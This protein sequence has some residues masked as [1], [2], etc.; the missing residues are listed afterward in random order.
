MRRYSESLDTRLV[1]GPFALFLVAM[2]L[3]PAVHGRAAQETAPLV[4]ANA[5][6]IDG[7][8]AGPRPDVTLVIEN[9]RIASIVEGDAPETPPGA[10]VVDLSGRFILPGLIDAHVHL[11]SNPEAE[12]ALRELLRAGVTTVRDMGG[13]ARTL[14]VLARDVGLGEIPA[15]DIHY[16]A[17]FY[18]PAFLQDPRS[19]L[20]ARGREPG[21]APWSRVVTEDSDLPQIVAEARGAGATGIKIY[22]AM[23]PELLARV[24]KE[25][26]AQGLKVWSHATI[27][28]S[29]P[30][31]AV[32]AGVHVLSHSGGL[33]PEARPDVPDSYTEA[34]ME[35]M[36]KQDFAAV[37]PAA[38]PFDDLY[39]SM[40]R[41]GT[42]LE[43]TMSAGQRQRATRGREEQAEYLARAARRIDMAARWQWACGATR[44]ASEAGVTIVAGTDSNGGVPVA[45][46]MET[47][48]RCG[49]SPLDAIRAATL[50]A[51]RAIGIEATHG[52]VEVGKAADLAIVAGDPTEDIANVRRVVGTVKAGRLYGAESADE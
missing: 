25:A 28:P 16:S 22:S 51:A 11:S 47:L 4:L 44:A 18:G 2:L 1:R 13:D 37:D 15:P 21:T 14:A 32:A 46:E 3:A 5:T 19:R 41:K 31:D 23:A 8:G 36:P 10:R 49:L 9:G 20:S 38:A 50:N 7:I 42:M 17:L 39:A 30:S 34:I 40:R 35:W 29:R 26:H 45:S 43:P 48:V 33:Y 52:S 27:F 24:V 12:T 6:L